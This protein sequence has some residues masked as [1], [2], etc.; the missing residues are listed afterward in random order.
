MRAAAAIEKYYMG[1]NHCIQIKR[2]REAIRRFCLF[3]H[4]LPAEQTPIQLQIKVLQRSSV[5]LGIQ[6]LSRPIMMVRGL[7]LGETSSC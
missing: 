5:I 3:C 7:D 4:S 6:S 2:K 1:D